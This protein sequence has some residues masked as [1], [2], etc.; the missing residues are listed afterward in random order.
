DKVREVVAVELDRLLGAPYLPAYVISELAYHPERIQ[1]L[2][3]AL[4]GTRPTDLGS[5][6]VAKIRTQIRRE[7]R[8]GRLR[9]VAAEQFLVNLLSLC[10]FPFAARPMLDALLGLDGERFP[11]FI[12][13]RK[14]ELPEF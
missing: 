4:T 6:V 7:V 12:R 13:E 9:P 10:I 5:A 1:Q 11:G 2:L 8:A 14:R 3:A